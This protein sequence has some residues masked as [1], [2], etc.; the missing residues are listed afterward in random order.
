MA[1]E[2][3]NYIDGRWVAGGSLRPSINPSDI[4]DI[5]GYFSECNAAQVEQ[6][7]AAARAGGGGLGRLAA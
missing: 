6:A 4:S 3:H 7:I 2:K 5:V 1:S